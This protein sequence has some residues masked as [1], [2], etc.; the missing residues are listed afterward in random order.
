MSKYNKWVCLGCTPRFGGTLGNL[1][2]SAI[3][4]CVDCGELH[5]S[6][7][8]LSNWVEDI[9]GIGEETN[10][11]DFCCCQSQES[12]SSGCRCDLC[13]YKRAAKKT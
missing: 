5:M 3:F 13:I 6:A 11:D 7:L 9:A 2:R 8:C 10:Y 1:F 12:Y 4:V